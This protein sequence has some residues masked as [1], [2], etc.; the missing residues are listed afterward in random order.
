MLPCTSINTVFAIRGSVSLYGQRFFFCTDGCTAK[1][2]VLP[3]VFVVFSEGVFIVSPVSLVLIGVA[4]TPIGV[5][6]V[7][8][9]LTVP[10]SIAH[11]VVGCIGLGT[12]APHAN[13]IADEE[14]S[15]QRA[16]MLTTSLVLFSIS[17]SNSSHVIDAELFMVTHDVVPLYS[18]AVTLIVPV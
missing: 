7:A 13:L 1:R 5:L 17:I 2:P 18:C 9:S 6:H 16:V 10:V 4:I 15:F 11:V 12:F 14:D 8:I 3:H